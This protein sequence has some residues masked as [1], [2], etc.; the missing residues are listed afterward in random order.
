MSEPTAPAP[1]PP[2]ITPPRRAGGARGCLGD[3]L[4]GLLIVLLSVALSVAAA[5]AVA[6]GYFGYTPE[7]PG[8]IQ[9]LQTEVVAA[10]LEL[11]AL[12]QQM[13]ENN[14]L[15]A[16]VQSEARDSRTAVALFSTAQAARAA[17]LD[18]LQRR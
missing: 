3:G 11:Q 16:T 6:Y 18:E 1:T 9:V 17:Q 5:G 12:G 7:A 4:R 14:A 8:R 15:A 13:Q 2:T 10:Q